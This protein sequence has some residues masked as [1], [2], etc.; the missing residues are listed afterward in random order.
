[1]S[2]IETVEALRERLGPARPTTLAKILPRVDAQ[3]AEFLR[4]SPFAVISTVGLDGTVEASPK[5]D[6]PGFI[7]L[8][9]DR[10]LLLPERA[11]NN[12]AFGLQNILANGQRQFQ[13][14]ETTEA[15]AGDKGNLKIPGELILVVRVFQGSDPVQM[16]ARFRYQLREGVLRIG[17]K[18]A[19]PDLAVEEAFND[20]TAAVQAGVPVRVNDGRR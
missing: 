12:L 2:R 9:D 17:I 19:E 8:E 16:T 14:E 15:K 6:E 5:G 18:L 20:V 11:G 7:R 1:M 4:V 13:W 10:T 3:G